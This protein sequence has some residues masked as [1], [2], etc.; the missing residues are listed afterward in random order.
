MRLL[1]LLIATLPCHA[2]AQACPEPPVAEMQIHLDAVNAARARARLA[3]VRLSRELS[4]L[5]QAH[6]C[7]M[8]RRTYFDHRSPEGATLMD[9]ARRAGLQ[10]RCAVGENIARGQPDVPRVMASWMRSPGHRGNILKPAFRE[11]GLGRAPGAHWVQVF[12]APC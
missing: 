6:A 1:V 8:A 10:G 7:D 4:V 11:V 2:A 12:A 9:R 5:A 3:P